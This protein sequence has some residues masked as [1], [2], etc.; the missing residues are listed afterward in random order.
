MQINEEE[1][2]ILIKW[3]IEYD[4]EFGFESTAEWD[5]LDRLRNEN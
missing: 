2:G 4:A 5:L 1:I 3:S